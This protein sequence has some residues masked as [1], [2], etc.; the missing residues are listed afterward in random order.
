MSLHISFNL[1][2]YGRQQ[3]LHMSITSRRILILHGSE[4][5]VE[6]FATPSL[7]MQLKH[8]FVHLIQTPRRH[9]LIA[10]S[11]D[12]NKISVPLKLRRARVCPG[13]PH[14]ASTR[15]DLFE[16][17]LRLA[18]RRCAGALPVIDDAERAAAVAGV[19]L[20]IRAV[21]PGVA[22]SIR[23]A[24]NAIRLVPA[25]GSCLVEIQRAEAVRLQSVAESLLIGAA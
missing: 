14:S 7:P 11:H 6:L 13:L 8:C 16:V 4:F 20:V 21:L 5:Y 24:V 19:V 12:A 1:N 17:A 3:S 22:V 25:G 15:E 18:I 2:G 10:R 9:I 23:V